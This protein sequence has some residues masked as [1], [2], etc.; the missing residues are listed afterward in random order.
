MSSPS[1]N[2]SPSSSAAA[3]TS[4]N[5]ACASFSAASTGLN[6]TPASSSGDRIRRLAS[7]WGL[8][9]SQPTIL[10]P[11]R[12]TSWKGQK[13]L[14]SALAKLRHT[15]AI[16]I[17]AGGNQ[18]RDNYTASLIALA[19]NLG[20]ADRVRIV[21]HN[22]DMPAAMMLA[23]I[24]VNASTDPE[25]FGRTIVEAQA[26]GRI[27]IAAD[28]GG[29]RETIFANE[30]G[31]LFPPGDASAFAAVIDAA[32]DMPTETRIA[33]GQNARAHV[34]ENHSIAVMQQKVLDVYAELLR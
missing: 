18:G 4:K 24:I 29:A 14:I 1:A 12:L 7:A 32:L 2:T 10:L 5:P 28:H 26:M 23:D 27:V 8:D 13:L 3:T 20:V 16:A 22:E 11:G 17:L 30:T 19:H 33:W 9:L 6:S 15:D 25:A 31:F 21:G 34:L